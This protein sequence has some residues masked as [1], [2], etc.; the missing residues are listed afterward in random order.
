MSDYTPSPVPVRSW[1]V[2]HTWV[3]NIPEDTWG[4][5]LAAEL[6]AEQFVPTPALAQAAADA[7]HATGQ[8]RFDHD[9]R[10]PDWWD[11]D[12]MDDA[13]TLLVVAG[14]LPLSALEGAQS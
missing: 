9:E 12:Q 10:L 4:A 13:H 1:R 8:E 7:I 5:D 11:Q 2:G 14:F 3:A 6:L